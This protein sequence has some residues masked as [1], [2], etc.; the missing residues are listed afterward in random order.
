MDHIQSGKRT[1]HGLAAL[2]IDALDSVLRACASANL[3]VR[4]GAVRTLDEMLESPRSLGIDEAAI[5]RIKAAL[6]RT[7]HEDNYYIRRNSVGAL[8]R[9]TVMTSRCCCNR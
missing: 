1:T 5:A 4:D 7:V 8:G 2:G 6:I 3:H 9:L